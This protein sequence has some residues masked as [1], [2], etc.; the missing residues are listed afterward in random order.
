[1]AFGKP[2]AL[3]VV[4]FFCGAEAAYP[5][6]FPF[7]NEKLQVAVPLA[8]TP[9]YKFDEDDP[10][11]YFYTHVIEKVL[12][13][14]D[15]EAGYCTSSSGALMFAYA[16]F[17]YP[18]VLNKIIYN[19]TRGENEKIMDK[20]FLGQVGTDKICEVNNCCKDLIGLPGTSLVSEPKVQT[21][22]TWSE[23]KSSG[24]CPEAMSEEMYCTIFSYG[25]SKTC[26]EQWVSVTDR[27]FVFPCY[28]TFVNYIQSCK[29]YK[30][31]GYYLPMYEPEDY[32]S[33][34]SGEQN[35]A[36]TGLWDMGD[37]VCRPYSY[38]YPE[39]ALADSSSDS[40]SESEDSG[41]D[42]GSA[43]TSMLFF[44]VSMPLSLFF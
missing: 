24:S 8:S 35:T 6:T 4:A 40:G 10:G 2:W 12:D 44:L 9:S 15:I 39:F 22:S 29:L 13:E 16:S 20:Q 14:A 42:S 25:L 27:L 31:T 32:W 7:E 11:G 21:Y 34:Q 36:V 28:D 41:T 1:M 3:V 5:T 33:K 19:C 26:M 23:I 37:K 43:L 18:P 30:L 38:F 17:N